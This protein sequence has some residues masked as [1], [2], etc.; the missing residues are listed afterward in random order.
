[1]VVSQE[2]GFQSSPLSLARG[3]S[4]QPT[5]QPLD[6][7]KPRDSRAKEETREGAAAGDA[8]TQPASGNSRVKARRR[9][10]PRGE[11]VADRWRL[12]T[13]SAHCAPLLPNRPP[14]RPPPVPR[15]SRRE[16][17]VGCGACGRS[18]GLLLLPVPLTS[19]PYPIPHPGSVTLPPPTLRTRMPC[20]EQPSSA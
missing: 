10:A 2:W 13:G 20:P 7:G 3:P 8:N 5:T 4:P 1:M 15:V 18:R 14:A 6:A 17:G 11:A 9:R 12:R 19:I 16:S